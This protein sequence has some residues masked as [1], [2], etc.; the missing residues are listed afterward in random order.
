MKIPSENLQPNGARESARL[1]FVHLAAG[2]GAVLCGVLYYALGLHFAPCMFHVVTGYYC[3]TC[4]ATRAVHELLHF[5]F[6][7]SF[8]LSPVPIL[9][10]LFLLS[11]LVCELVGVLQKRRIRYRWGLL[12]LYIIL[13][14]TLLHC[15]LRNFGF[16]PPP[17]ALY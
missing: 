8:L 1:F 7:N 6:V 14:V 15:L 2:A 17:N 16:L 9:L 3:M 10:A 5:R 12:A 4:G 11:V 13:G